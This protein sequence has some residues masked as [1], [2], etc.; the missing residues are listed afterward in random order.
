MTFQT[1]ITIKYNLNNLI[2]AGIIYDMHFH[3]KY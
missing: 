3:F 1:N 2:I